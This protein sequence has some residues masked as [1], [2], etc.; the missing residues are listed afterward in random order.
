MDILNTGGIGLLSMYKNNALSMMKEIHPDKIEWHHWLFGEADDNYWN[1]PNHVR[2]YCDWLAE[3]LELDGVEAWY[4][5]KLE[6]FF[7]YG[8]RG[9]LFDNSPHKLL[10]CA[11]PFTNWRPWRFDVSFPTLNVEMDLR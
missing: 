11:Y 10:S 2:K 4:R 5:L 6:D 9:K 3:S 7:C 8:M 1:N